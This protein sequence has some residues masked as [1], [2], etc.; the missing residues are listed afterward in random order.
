MVKLGWK[1][2]KS[3]FWATVLWLK[4]SFPPGTG[5]PMAAICATAS[6]QGLSGGSGRGEKTGNCS[7]SV[8]YVSSLPPL[9]TSSDQKEDF[10]W[11]LFCHA[12]IHFW[13][14][15]C[16]WIQIGSLERK[17]TGSRCQIDCA[18]RSSFRL[19]SACCH[20]TVLRLLPNAFCPRSSVTVGG[21]VTLDLSP[22]WWWW[23]QTVSAFLIPGI[24][25]NAL[26][27]LFC[28]LKKFWW[29]ELRNHLESSHLKHHT[30]GWS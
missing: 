6:R 25:Q 26:G 28:F 3:T 21:T 30:T 29:L 5:L 13:W 10:F 14:L 22:G 12:S 15:S 9:H 20:F 24:V 11:K 1:N 23:G 2:L 4:I 7:Y 17:K 19:W 8:L 18:L 16:L 27:V